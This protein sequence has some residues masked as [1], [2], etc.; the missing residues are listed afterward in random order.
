MF[1]ISKALIIGAVAILSTSAVSAQDNITASFRYQ[2]ALTVEANYDAFELTAKR[3][4]NV[5]SNLVEFKA[6]K[7]CRESLLE[8]AVAATKVGSFIAYHQNLDSSVQIASAR[9]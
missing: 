4:C 1:T 3:A 6:R 9:R 2:R 7:N 8:Q 5:I